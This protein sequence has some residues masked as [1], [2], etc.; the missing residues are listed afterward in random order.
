MAGFLEEIL[1]GKRP[2]LES[3]LLREFSRIVDEVFKVPDPEV[4]V[5]DIDDDFGGSGDAK[6]LELLLMD[7]KSRHKDTA[8]ALKAVEAERDALKEKI[9][10]LRRELLT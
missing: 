8:T 7:E 1:S 5:D 3:L 2:R 6:K 10:S 4:F 9:E